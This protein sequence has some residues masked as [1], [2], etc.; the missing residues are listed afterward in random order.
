LARIA[1]LFSVE[2][3]DTVEH[4]LPGW[5]KIP[6]GLSIIA[7]C[8]ERAGHEVRCWVVCPDTRLD[9]V[10]QEILC[11]FACE[12]VAASAVSTQ[13]PLIARLCQRIK[14]LKPSIPTLLGGIHATIRPEECIAHP[15]IDA[16][17]VGEGED[18]AV[19]WANAIAAGAQ[20]SGIPGAWIK[21]PGRGE[22]DRTP[23]RP[24]RTDLDELPMLNYQHW[25]RWIDPQDRRF[26]VVVGR[27]CPYGC[28]YCSN[29]ALR[30]VQPG[31]YVRLRS[32]GNILAEIEMVHSRFPDLTSL[33]LEIET[34]GASIPWAL[35]L[36]DSLEALNAR[37]ERP[38]AFRANL[39]L[40]SHLMEQKEQL[41]ALVKAFRRANLLNLNVGLESGSPRIRKEILNRP[42]YTNADLIQFCEIARQHGISVALFT[43]IGVPTESPG[44][45][46]ATSIVA[47]ACNPAGIDPSIFYP[48]PG[49]KLHKQAAEMHLIDPRSL[50]VTAERSRVYLKLKDFPRWQVF[51]EYVLIEWRVFHGRRS[52]FRILRTMLSRSLKILPG[53]LIS[54]LHFKDS[55]HFQR[56]T[57][58][59]PPVRP[60][61]A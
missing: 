35:H 30:H 26:R 24:F 17:C 29:H 28:T 3:Y 45:A 27:G 46:I 33:Y 60:P 21:I 55:F 54:V 49:T 16:V 18:V 5:D 4:P 22:V 10:A 57:T 2:H 39:A 50:G 47:R 38:I 59:R 41:D 48:Y 20:P 42:Y 56:Q 8:L 36:C 9:R 37:I 40:T 53:L 58:V 15:A 19:A 43:L 13:F 1:C 34:I 25:E 7:A 23:P 6:F 44:E 61:V 12:M 14:E 52:A 32:P 31:R 51:L 11:E